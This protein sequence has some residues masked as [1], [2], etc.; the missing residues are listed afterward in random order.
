MKEDFRGIPMVKTL[1]SRCRGYRFESLV[2]VGED[3]TCQVAQKKKK[4][5]KEKKQKEVK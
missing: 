4:K 3:P 5:M 1:S 2:L